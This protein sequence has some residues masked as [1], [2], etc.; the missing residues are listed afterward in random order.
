[1]QAL[2]LPAL[3]GGQWL[4]E[5]FYLFRRNPPLIVFVVFG[6]WFLLLVADLMPVIG[7]ALAS[8]CV[9]GLS[10]GIMNACRAIDARQPVRLD[11]VVSGFRE[12]PRALLQLGVAYL[13]GT[14]TILAL[15]SLVDDGELLRLMKSGRSGTGEAVDG[16]R[17]V[18]AL[19]AALLMM[20]PFLMLFWFAPMLVA[21]NGLSPL[22][23]MFFSFVAAWRNWRAFVVYAAMTAAT[24]IV[25]PGI[26]LAVLGGLAQSLSR[27][28]VTLFT[29]P[30]LLVF[31]PTL[32]ASFY[33]SYREVFAPPQAN[34]A[35]S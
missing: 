6:Y 3:R 29:L 27:T 5:G 19:Q 35:A 12:H 17:L 31:V 1:M 33:V 11:V 26:L 20:V 34:G 10:M 9:P 8:I 25:L 15:A 7:P 16:Q 18:M 14:L 32:F 21:W 28:L 23:A 24:A 2:R 4:L 30:L 22:K 13:A